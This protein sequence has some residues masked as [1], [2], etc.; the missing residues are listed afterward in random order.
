MI[1]N[2]LKYTREH[3]WIRV[4]RTLGTIGITHFAQS[5]LGDVVF[6]ELPE[7]GRVLKLGEAFGVVESVKTVS[8]LYS[9]ISGR[10]VKVNE[11][12]MDAPETV[13]QDPYGE[14][15]IIVIEIASPAELGGLL[16]AEAYQQVTAD[17]A[18]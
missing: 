18:H 10:V 12:L 17:A 14:G 9:P 7:V 15:W 5:A 8:D 11:K 2:D 1:P 16:D 13:N 4:E 6:V 3:E